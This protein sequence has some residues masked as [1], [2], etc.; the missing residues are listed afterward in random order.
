MGRADPLIVWNT[1]KRVFRGHAI[2]YSSLKQKQFRSKESMLTKEMGGRIVQIDS[3]EN[4]TM[5][6]KNKSLNES[7]IQER[8]SVMYYRK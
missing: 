4:C 1:F 6:A 8:S 7:F 2:Q 5:E 3:N